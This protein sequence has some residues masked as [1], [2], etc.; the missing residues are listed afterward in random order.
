MTASARALP[1]DLLHA[2]EEFARHRTVLVA[3]DFDG[4]LAPIVDV[5]GGARALAGSAA[6]L[7]ALA[8]RP[9][10]R[11]AL[12][13]GRALADLR[14]VAAPPA[15]VL[16]VASHGA[17][18]D[19]VPTPLDDDA[20]ARLADVLTGLEQVAAAHP[21]THVERKPAGGVLHTRRASRE[22]AAA[23]GEAVRGGVGSQ[24]GVHTMQGKEVVELS[25][26]RADK[27]T[28]LTTLRERLGVDAVL[29]A[30]DDV[31]DETVFAVLRGDDVGV[32][33][34]DGETAARHRVADPTAVTAVL[35]HLVHL[36]TRG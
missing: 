10:A 8:R 6:A 34:G 3:L 4:V 26:V 24:A 1:P 36:L 20:Q 23:A 7:A 21:G 27:G 2:L 18:L 33:V 13:S 17:E 12:V 32:K 30:G 5:P 31:T 35:E 15:G 29:Y 25:V 19:G 22:T 14:A 16:L 11:V 28:A 9:R